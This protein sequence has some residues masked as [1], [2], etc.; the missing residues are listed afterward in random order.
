MIR[1]RLRFGYCRSMARRMWWRS[2]DIC[3]RALSHR[4]GK[5]NSWLLIPQSSVHI[6]NWLT[7]SAVRRVSAVIVYIWWSLVMGLVVH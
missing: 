5:L 3:Q 4:V 2:L 7:T 6:M 1:S